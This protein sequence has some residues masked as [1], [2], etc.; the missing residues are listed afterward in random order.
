MRNILV[1][2]C[3]KIELLETGR[4]SHVCWRSMMNHYNLPAKLQLHL[5]HICCCR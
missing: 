3:T 4:N 2:F 5:L 1:P